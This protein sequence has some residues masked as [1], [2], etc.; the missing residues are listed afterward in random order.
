MDS[1]VYDEINSIKNL[2][3]MSKSR[4]RRHAV[5]KEFVLFIDSS[6]PAHFFAAAFSMLSKSV[7]SVRLHVVYTDKKAAEFLDDFYCYVCP[8]YTENKNALEE[9]YPRLKIYDSTES[10]LSSQISY[11]YKNIY[12]VSY[13]DSIGKAYESKDAQNKYLEDLEKTIKYFSSVG[14]NVSFLQYSIIPELDALKGELVS[15]AEREYEVYASDK[16]ELSPEKFVLKAENVL[17]ENMSEELKMTALRINNIF[18][19]GVSNKYLGSVISQAKRGKFV[20]DTASTRKHICLN[21]IRFASCASF[22]MVHKGENGNIYNLRQFAETPFE[23][24]IK[25]YDTLMDH[26]FDLESISS[27]KAKEEYSLLS[28]KKVYPLIPKKYL[29]MDS[30]EC[31]Y[32]TLISQIG[33]DFIDRNLNKKYDGKLDEIKKIEIEMM[34]EIKRICEKHNIKY[35]LVGGSLLGAI[36]HGGFIPWDD[37]LDIGMLRE[38]YEKFRAVAPNELDERFSY[39]SFEHEPSSHYIFDKIRLK[40]TYFTTKFSNRFKMENGL[41]ID[42][43]IYDKTANNLKA[44]KRHITALRWGARLINIRWVNVPRKGV[45]YRFSKLMLPFMRLFPLSVYHKV[46]NTILKWYNKT[47]NHYLIDGVGL[48]IERGAFTDSWFDEIIEMPFEDITLPVPAG[49]DSYLRHW[50]G[51]KYM[52]L[53]PVSVRNSGHDLRRVDLGKYLSGFGYEEGEYHKADIKGE[54]FDRK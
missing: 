34:K 46:F 15:L 31:I 27:G 23:L 30:S 38:D 49:Y 39:Q 37:D 17:R 44:Q 25:A 52:E 42:I 3:T 18:G 40:D 2:I 32:R 48:N 50:Y 29:E 16:D 7:D 20:L 12:V 8:S 35:F 36:R 10:F 45:A 13:L 4:I 28:N 1:F 54:L 11:R 51:D 6:I 14:G 26:N 53:P 22:F 21:Y 19:P 47:D 41:F 24:S 5:K 9:I 33:V 43:L